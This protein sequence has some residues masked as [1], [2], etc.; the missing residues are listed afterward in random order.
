MPANQ[1]KPRRP[2]GRLDRTEAALER[3]TQRHEALTQTFEL[4]TH[5][6]QQDAA[7]FRALARIAAIHEGR[8]SDLED[9]PS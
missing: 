2:R 3:L 7:N 4:L 8:T 5:D 9:R 6:V 1:S